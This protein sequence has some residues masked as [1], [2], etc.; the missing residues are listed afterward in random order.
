MQVAYKTIS[1][2]EFD[3]LTQTYKSVTK[4]VEDTS[5]TTSSFLNLLG[6]SNNSEESSEQDL[7]GTTQTSQNSSQEI[8][9]DFNSNLLAYRFRQN[10]NELLAHQEKLAQ[11]NLVDGLVSNLA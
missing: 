6:S 1:L 2:L 8:F 7:L 11:Q 4:Q 5:A 9:S 3:P 10:E